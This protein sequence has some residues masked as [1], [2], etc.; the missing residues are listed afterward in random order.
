M[1]MTHTYLCSH[2]KARRGRIYGY[3]SGHQANVPEFCE[4]LTVLLITQSLLDFQLS[5]RDYTPGCCSP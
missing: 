4:H 5:L 1:I 2:Y 3:I